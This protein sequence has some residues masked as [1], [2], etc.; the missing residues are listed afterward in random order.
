VRYC[1]TTRPPKGW[2]QVV[3]QRTLR[4]KVTQHSEGKRMGEANRKT[5]T[6]WRFGA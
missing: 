1:A 5:G 3:T 6:G 2:W 4:S